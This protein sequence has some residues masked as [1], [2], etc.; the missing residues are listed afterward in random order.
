MSEDQLLKKYLLTTAALHRL[1][2][3]IIADSASEKPTLSIS[4]FAVVTKL[5][6]SQRNGVYIP[7]QT[8]EGEKQRVRVIQHGWVLAAVHLAMSAKDPELARMAAEHLKKGYQ[9]RELEWSERMMGGMKTK[10]LET[11]KISEAAEAVRK[12]MGETGR[13][14][15]TQANFAREDLILAKRSLP[16][17]ELL[18]GL[19][20]RWLLGG[21]QHLD[22]FQGK[23]PILSQLAIDE[24]DFHS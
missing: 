12:S 11:E 3:M 4:G 9:A 14:V 16:K 2:D 1:I 8:L 21:T 10:D 19:G 20:A 23:E 7:G 18:P 5:L 17:Q 15:R 13:M 22:L 6:R 24:A